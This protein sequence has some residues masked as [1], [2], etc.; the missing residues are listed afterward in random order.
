M[1]KIILSI[2]VLTALYSCKNKDQQSEKT[3]ATDS[4]SVSQSTDAAKIAFV[5]KETSPE[6]VTQHLAKNNDT[7]YITNFFATWCGPCMQEIPSFKEKMQELKGKP[8]KFTFVNLDEKAD[9]DSA[10][11]NFVEKNNLEGSVILVDGTKLDQKFFT[12]NFKQWTGGSIPFTF[13]RKGEKVEEYS[14]MMTEEALNSK[15]SSLLQ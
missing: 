8:V 10:V 12:T 15:I 11:K 13:M 3:V 2:F 7:L 1:K 14:G 4:V 6:E 9:W 5:P